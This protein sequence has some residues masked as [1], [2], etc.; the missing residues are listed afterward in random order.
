MP[1]K[2][3][4]KRKVILNLW[5]TPDLGSQQKPLQ[6][7]SLTTKKSILSKTVLHSLQIT[8][9]AQFIQECWHKWAEMF[10]NLSTWDEVRL[11]E[12]VNNFE[13]MK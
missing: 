8:I 1:K 13:T 6:N 12:L 10:Q 2:N 4:L 7:L 5:A 9:M 11:L 3:T